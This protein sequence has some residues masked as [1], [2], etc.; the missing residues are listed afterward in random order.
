MLHRGCV[1]EHFDSERS[2]VRIRY[3]ITKT[4]CNVVTLSFNESGCAEVLHKVYSILLPYKCY[5][6]VVLQSSSIQCFTLLEN[7]SPGIRRLATQRWR[8]TATLTCAATRITAPPIP[9]RRRTQT[10]AAI[11]TSAP[12]RT[13]PPLPRPLARPPPSP[14]RSPPSL[15]PSSLAPSLAPSLALSLALSLPRPRHRPLLHA[16]TLSLFLR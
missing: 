13:A 11:H 12:P 7:D 4:F 14:P 16:P 2:P 3:G 5:T 6:G 8:C 9:R 1:A 10:C 15:A